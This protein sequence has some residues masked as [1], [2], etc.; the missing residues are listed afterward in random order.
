M[1][2][3]FGQHFQIAV[4]QQTGRH[5]GVH[6]LGDPQGGPGMPELVGRENGNVRMSGV[7]GPHKGLEHP[8][9]PVV[10]LIGFSLRAVENEVGGDYLSS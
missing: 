2:I 6:P 8:V 3:D 5:I 1:V 7:E 10:G 4:T 9:G